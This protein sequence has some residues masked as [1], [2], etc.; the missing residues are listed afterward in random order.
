MLWASGFHSSDDIGVTLEIEGNWKYMFNYLLYLQDKRSYQQSPFTQEEEA[1]GP[2]K[3]AHED[4]IT[5]GGT[6]T[7]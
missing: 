4:I 2:A 7:L 1:V 3:S 6:P 5:A